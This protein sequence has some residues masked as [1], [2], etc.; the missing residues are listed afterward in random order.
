MTLG[1]C[2]EE[3]MI[4]FLGKYTEYYLYTKIKRKYTIIFTFYLINIKPISNY[5]TYYK[6]CPEYPTP[7][8][9]IGPLL[10]LASN[11]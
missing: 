11:L 7:N 2:Y 10:Q 9:T 8:D 1:E 6:N 4:V 5:Y 3:V